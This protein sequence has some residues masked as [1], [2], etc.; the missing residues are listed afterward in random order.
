V[1]LAG[2]P[3]TENASRVAAIS[4][5]RIEDPAAGGSPS[6]SHTAAVSGN[7]CRSSELPV[8][9]RSSRRVTTNPSRARR[10]AGATT[11]IHGRRPYLR[12]SS[13]RPAGEPGTPAASGPTNEASGRGSRLLS[14]YMSCEA[15]AGAVSRKSRVLTSRPKRRTANP[16]PPRLPACGWT[17]ARAS[18]V[19]TAAS[20]AL[21]PARKI[22]RPASVAAGAALDTAPPFPRTAAGWAASTTA[23]QKSSSVRNTELPR[24]GLCSWVA[25]RI[26]D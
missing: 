3:R 25:D 26:M 2:T 15:A 13:C 20:A 9:A 8:S 5:S 1:P 10:I 16:P 6:G 18:A 21:P 17:T 7:F 22:S 23:T 14:R 4:G 19:A 11:L 24:R 12:W